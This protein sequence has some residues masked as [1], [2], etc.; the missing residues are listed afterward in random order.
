MEDQTGLGSRLRDF[1]TSG[2]KGYPFHVTHHQLK[3]RQAE[4]F[5]LL[6]SEGLAQVY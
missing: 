1:T 6:Y 5:L 4:K 2:K 3:R